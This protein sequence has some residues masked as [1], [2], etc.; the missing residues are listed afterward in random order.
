MSKPTRCKVAFVGGG[1]RT[2]LVIFGLQ[3]S[4]WLTG[5]EELVL[6]DPD[7]ERAQL[8]T[9]L[10]QAIVAAEGKS[11]N[12]RFTASLSMAPAL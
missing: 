2:P 11:L 5:V 4:A 8:I 9:E 10:G 6:F 7:T 3:Q 1:L 12:V